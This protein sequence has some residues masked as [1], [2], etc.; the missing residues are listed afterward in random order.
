MNYT[1]QSWLNKRN[2]AVV[3]CKVHRNFDQNNSNSDDVNQEKLFKGAVAVD[4]IYG[5]CHGK[6]V[7]EIDLAASAI[8]YS[9]AHP[10]KVV[11]MDNHMTSSGSY[12]TFQ[13]WLGRLAGG[14]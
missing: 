1:P 14:D 5:L 11:N 7:S 10:K 12:S 9:L 2:Q 13:N 8:K 4:A 6:Y 3:C